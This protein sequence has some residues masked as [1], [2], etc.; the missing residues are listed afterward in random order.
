MLKKSIKPIIYLL[1]LILVSKVMWEIN[2]TDYIFL[3]YVIGLFGGW[4][5][6]IFINSVQD[7]KDTNQWKTSQTKHKRGG[8]INN[9]TYIRISFSYLF[10][11]KVQDKYFLVKNNK[12]KKF[13]PVGGVYSMSDKEYD[14]LKNIFFIED[15]DKVSKENSPKHEY[16]LKFKN[17]YLRKFVRRFNKEKNRE[18]YN[19]LSREFCEELFDTN[20]LDKASFGN[21]SYKYC[22]RHESDF[23][24]S[25][26]FGCYELLLADIVEVKLTP[27]QID[28]FVSIL[29]INSDEYIFAT[30]E[31]I[32]TLGVKSGTNH[33]AE[34]IGDHS[35][36]I[37]QGNEED[38][39]YRNKHKNTITIS[40]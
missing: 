13:Q 39:I 33:L 34:T 19:D 28:M 3:V 30:A 18:D 32:D 36:K 25:H 8:F 17:K 29:N 31:E 20:I 7:L 24:F 27:K 14:E 23:K 2:S 11:I 12:T 5:F 38:L 40:L 4:F 22:G 35:R 16:R 1:L 9:S 15:D 26:H 21:L 10:R 37:L 6:N